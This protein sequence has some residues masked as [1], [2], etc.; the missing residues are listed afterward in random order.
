[1]KYTVG[2]FFRLNR[3]ILPIK[4]KQDLIGFN[5]CKVLPE[6]QKQAM[7]PAFNLV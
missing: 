1:M 5:S 7:K 4:A 6:K 3:L 2:R